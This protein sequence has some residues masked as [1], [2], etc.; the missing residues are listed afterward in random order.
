MN[1]NLQFHWRNKIG[2]FAMLCLM[3][4]SMSNAQSQAITGLVTSEGQPLPGVSIIIKGTSQGTVSDFDGGYSLRASA[5]SVLVFSYIGYVTKEVTVGAN[6]TVNVS[7][8][9]D[10]AKLDEVVVIGYGKQKRLEVSGSVVSVKGE[11]VQKFTS[12]NFQDALQGRVAGVSVMAAGGEPGGEAIIQI[13]GTN[14]LS[15]R[16]RG[17]SGEPDPNLNLLNPTENGLAPLY[18]V[19]GVQLETNPNLSS[20]DIENIEILKDAA[21]TSIYGTR[22]AA[23]VIIITTKKGEVGKAKIDFNLTT[24]VKKVTSAINTANTADAFLIDR[25]V[26]DNNSP[27]LRYFS[28]LDRNKDALDYDTDW[29][30]FVINDFAQSLNA[31]L[32]V[33]GGNKDINYNVTLDNYQEDGVY[34]KSNLNRTN[35]RTNATLKKGKFS[36]NVGTNISAGKRRLAPWGL[37]YDAIRLAPFNRP[38]DIGSGSINTPEGAVQPDGGVFTSTNNV[39]G[40]LARKFSADNQRKEFNLGANV[41]LEYKL[42][43]SLRARTTLSGFR[44]NTESF[45]YTPRQ[46]IRSQETGEL[47]QDPRPADLTNYNTTYQV[48]NRDFIL[49]YDQY[50][51]NHRIALLLGAESRELLWEEFR[52]SGNTF[53]SP[54]Q[55]TITSAENISRRE[56]T[57][58]PSS[59]NSYFSRLKY[60]YGGKYFLLANVRR[61]GT[62]KFIN[63]KIGYFGGVSGAWIVSKEGFFKNANFLSAVSNLKLRAS[64]GTVGNDRIPDFNFQSRLLSNANPVFGGGPQ[65]GAARLD[66]GN[67]NLKWETTESIN[68]GVDLGLF[69]GALTITADYYTAKKKDLL[70]QLPT[71]PS[72]GVQ[73]RPIGLNIASLTNEGLELS[74]GY[75]NN[76][77]A[78]K[79]SVAATY[80]KNTNTVDKLTGTSTDVI[81][82]GFP[83]RA[84]NNVIQTP[85]TFIRPGYSA[86]AFFLIPTDGVIKNQEE[87]DAYDALVSERLG[88]GNQ[89]GDLRYKD[90]ITEDLLMPQLDANGNPEIDADGNVIMVAGQDGIL[91]SGD[92]IINDDDRIFMGNNLPDFEAGFNLNL[93][94]KNLDFTMQWFGMFGHKVFNG[95]KNLT[96]AHGTHKDIAYQH[97]ALN[98]NSSIPAR[99]QNGTQD[100]NYSSASDLFLEDG[101][102]VRLRNI[103][104]GYSLPLDKMKDIGLQKIRIFISAQNLLTIT[105]YSGYDPEIGGDGLATR[106]V[107]TGLQPVTAQ[108]IIGL[109][110]GF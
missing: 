79:W 30:D 21:T 7:L 60:E 3:S 37:L 51:G 78:V 106:G 107:D 35:L 105:D 108:G 32:R 14:T 49:D 25:T 71:V 85:V 76:S 31:N 61:N 53:V 15:S 23:G 70:F 100:P 39:V 68:Y 6:T 73:E 27:N 52:I 97:S 8:D 45:F 11:D 29:Q 22:G 66:L 40:D 91:D 81:Q 93:N 48:F 94:Y 103:Q 20:N 84:N 90:K 38:F 41:T 58:N 101:D 80:T 33:S 19:D 99:R 1:F 24:A 55:R 12:N 74:L 43:E 102:F 2:F 59:T 64:W 46:E 47:T 83:L 18:I 5:N 34:K 92:G 65:F 72:A 88:R 62:S 104:L 89:I 13:R 17:N 10:I 56:S 82:G 50:F 96:Y 42:F 26:H 63:N 44:A 36:L 98:P 77:K 28:I 109:Q 69:K 75:R 86:G 4:I 87:L 9:E 16:R 67:S 54:E 57:K 95:P 110:I